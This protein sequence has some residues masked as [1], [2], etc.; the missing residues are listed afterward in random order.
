MNS[1][2]FTKPYLHFFPK[3]SC[4]KKFFAQFLILFLLASCSEKCELPPFDI[5]IELTENAQKQLQEM[6]SGITIYLYTY[7]AGKNFALI[8]R[9]LSAK[10][11]TCHIEEQQWADCKKFEPQL[12]IKIVS[13]SNKCP[14]NL[15]KCSIYDAPYPQGQKVKI[16]C[17]IHNNTPQCH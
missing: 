6:E 11:G 12:N 5:D 4:A 14:S 10:G 8:H 9:P 15:L 13:S 16:K 1:S 7:D 2:Y 17:D 3:L